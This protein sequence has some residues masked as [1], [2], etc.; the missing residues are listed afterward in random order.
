MGKGEVHVQ[1]SP[2]N[3]TSIYIY[4]SCE[5]FHRV[6]DPINEDDNW[7]ETFSVE[8]ETEPW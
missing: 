2:P 4:I 5:R 3:E 6:E 8:N 1:K 7:E